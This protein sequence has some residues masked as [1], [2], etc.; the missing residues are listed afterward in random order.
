[1]FTDGEFE[2]MFIT[3]VIVEGIGAGS[4]TCSGAAAA[5]SGMYTHQAFSPL[6]AYRAP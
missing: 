1:M 6:M 5:P 4:D 2:D 3:D